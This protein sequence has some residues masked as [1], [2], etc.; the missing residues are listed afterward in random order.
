MKRMPVIVGA[1]LASLLVGCASTPVVVSP[2]G[3]NPIRPATQTVD[4][5]LEVFSAMTGRTEG[6]NPTWYQ[7]TDYTIYNQHGWAM[8]RV[9]NTVGYYETSPH[10]ISLA[11]GKYLVKAEAKDY[12]EVT[13]PVIIDPGCLT[14]V[15]LDDAWRTPTVVVNDFV[16][17][18]TGNPVG[19]SPDAK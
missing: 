14:R 13:V 12:P 9:R 5:Q 17:L 10:V 2:V 1:A 16:K 19:W 3:P 8:K 11:P 15:H 6:D 4:G 18:P 7:H